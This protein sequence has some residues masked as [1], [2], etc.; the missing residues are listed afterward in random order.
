MPALS[1]FRNSD[2][3]LAL[4][5]AWR[6]WTGELMAMVP[7]RFRPGPDKIP[8]ADIRPG[9]DAVE[10]E[11]ISEGVGQ[12]FADPR[13]LED[14]DAD[15]WAELAALI[16]GSRARIVLDAPDAYVTHIT[17][18][19]AARRRLKSAVALQLSQLSPLEPALLRWAMAATDSGADKV[20]IQVAMARSECV[21]RL[22]A[23]FGA[24]GIDPPPVHA[25]TPEATLE[26]AAGSRLAR[27]EG[28]RAD[29]KAWVTAALLI[30]TI[31]LTTTL[32]AKV[33]Q[34]SAENR[35]ETLAR[36][37][38]PR[39]KAE[40]EVRRSEAL[41]RDLRPLVA[42]PSVTAT[43]EELAARLPLTDYVKSLSQTGDRTLQFVI[44]TADAEAA[45]AALKGSPVLPYVALTDILPAANGRVTATFRTSPR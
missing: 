37:A 5:E 40:A 19:K 18:P 6:W 35:I 30:A 14:L 39:L 15:G 44:E 33:L 41:R 34:A 4:A 10:V 27:T 11:I 1:D 9:R 13:R 45:E 29:A 42:R 7:E 26:L 36:G 8:R 21:E 22:Q 32:G 25:A 3:G 2:A 24:N 20:E 16:E 12:R 28:G 17:L 23:L 31:P 38:A 43:L